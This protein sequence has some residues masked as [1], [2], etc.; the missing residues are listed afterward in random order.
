MAKKSAFN[1]PIL[2]LRVDVATA[3]LLSPLIE[4]D[5][6]SAKRLTVSVTV[7]RRF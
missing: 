4:G 3:K 5:A 7:E 1:P 2:L 6:L